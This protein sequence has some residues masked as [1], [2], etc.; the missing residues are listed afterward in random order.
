M[1][2]T[3]GMN[4]ENKIQS[5]IDSWRNLVVEKES[6]SKFQENQE[7]IQYL[8]SQIEKIKEEN[9]TLSD[10]VSKNQSDYDSLKASNESLL[11]QIK[12]KEKNLN[13][14]KEKSELLAKQVSI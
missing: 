8:N 7:K 6:K 1:K 4:L 5:K 3:T 10:L 13:E 9:N 14:I 11:T 12:T 2:V